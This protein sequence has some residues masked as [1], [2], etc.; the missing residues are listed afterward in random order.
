MTEG[1]SGLWPVLLSEAVGD[2]LADPA[3]P[4]VVFS[5]LVALTVAIAQNPWLEGSRVLEPGADW[6]EILIRGQQGFTYGIAEY[7]INRPGHNVIL[8]RIVI[9]PDA[10]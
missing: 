4:A 7:Y 1:D 9:S 3:V 10:G 8:T 5:A 2:T 6:R